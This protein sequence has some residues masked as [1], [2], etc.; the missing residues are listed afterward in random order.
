MSLNVSLLTGKN[1]NLMTKIIRT[2]SLLDT[3]LFSQQLSLDRLQHPKLESL[4]LKSYLTTQPE[5]DYSK[6]LIAITG[7][8]M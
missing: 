2:H 6:D 7:R 4:Q 8:P 1:L 5:Y 3:P